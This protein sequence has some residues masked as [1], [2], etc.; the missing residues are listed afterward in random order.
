[1]TDQPPAIDVEGCTGLRQFRAV[2]GSVR[3]RGE[4]CVLGPN[5]A[6]KTSTVEISKATASVRRECAY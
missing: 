2:M 6:G 1:V 3:V 5:G 4:I